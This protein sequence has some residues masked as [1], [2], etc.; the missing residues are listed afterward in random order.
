MYLDTI[1]KTQFTSEM[2]LAH[3]QTTFNNKFPSGM[4][5]HY[6]APLKAVMKNYQHYYYLEQ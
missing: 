3:I 2:H 5:L 4:K 1:S 6:S